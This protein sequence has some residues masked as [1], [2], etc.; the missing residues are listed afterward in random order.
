MGEPKAYRHNTE[1]GYIYVVFATS[2]GKAKSVLVTEDVIYPWEFMSAKVVREPRLDHL[3]LADG[4]I[5]DFMDPKQRRE[6]VETLDAYCDDDSF[7]PRV[8]CVRCNC[9]D[10][11]ERYLDYLAEWEEDN[12]SED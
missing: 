4:E 2:R 7:D 6:L 5:A 11:C 9:N 1:N 8:E 12:G 10:I 3:K